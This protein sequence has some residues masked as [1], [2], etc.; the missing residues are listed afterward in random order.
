MGKV[1][2]QAQT[3]VM[4]P[5]Q[6]SLSSAYNVYAIYTD[7]HSI[8]SN[9]GFDTDGYA[10]S[11]NALGAVRASNGLGALQSWRGNIFTLG[12]PNAL[13]GVSNTTIS[14]THGNYSQMLML[15][16]TAYGPI[17]N[18]AFVVTYTDGSTATTTFTMSDWANAQFYKGETVVSAQAYRNAEPPGTYTILYANRDLWLHH[19]P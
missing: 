14:L 17:A 11:A 13:S 3:V 15:A 9:G 2:M 1:N 18:A 8:P 7:G 6:F 4:T 16:A 10:Y 19:Q 12:P 5:T